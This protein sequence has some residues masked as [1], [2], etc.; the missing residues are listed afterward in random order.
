MRLLW[1]VRRPNTLKIHD[2]SAFYS[3]DMH[4]H[5]GSFQVFILELNEKS[6][7]PITDGTYGHAD[8]RSRKLRQ[9]ELIAGLKITGL[10]YA[11][12][13]SASGV[14]FSSML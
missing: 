13:S 3:F 6:V 2:G 5:D 10:I 8:L 9:L 7:L 12:A 11:D 14:Q 1:Q 4:N